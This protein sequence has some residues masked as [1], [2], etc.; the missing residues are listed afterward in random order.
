MRA[1]RV[2]ALLSLLPLLACASSGPSPIDGRSRIDRNNAARPIILQTEGA[3]SEQ[4]IAAPADDVWGALVATYESLGIPLS[5]AAG[6]RTVEN[7]GYPARRIDGQRMSRF[8]ECGSNVT[9]EIADSYRVTVSI[10]SSVEATSLGTSVVHTEARC[11]RHC[12]GYQE[13]RAA[14]F[15]EGGPG[16]ADRGA[17]VGVLSGAGVDP[18]S[19]RWRAPPSAGGPTLLALGPA[20]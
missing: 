15:V 9:G 19:A 14:L 8:F 16:A 5:E 17:V 18:P 12:E 4:A 1:R 10:R 20:S 13:R 7:R 6:T 3:T 11:R 2:T